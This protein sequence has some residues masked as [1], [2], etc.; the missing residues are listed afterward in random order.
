MTCL[1]ELGI[2]EVIK[3][4]DETSRRRHITWFQSWHSQSISLQTRHAD[5]IFFIKILMIASVVNWRLT[6]NTSCWTTS[7]TVNSK[8]KKERK[9]KM[10]NAQVSDAD[11]I[12]VWQ[13]VYHTLFIFSI[14]VKKI[15][16]IHSRTSGFVGENYGKFSRGVI[17]CPPLSPVL[18]KHIC[19]FTY[20][21][22]ITT[23]Q[24]NRTLLYLFSLL[25]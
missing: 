5:I 25:I 10:L 1:V 2:S 9:K 15:R 12:C 4:L 14:V 17:C 23:F 18:R 19:Y 6:R 7:I 13:Q 8:R 20:F 3:S 22:Y 11:D 16:C 21:L 24:V